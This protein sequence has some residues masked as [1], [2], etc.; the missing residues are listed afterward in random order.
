MARHIQHVILIIADR[1]KS[2]ARRCRRAVQRSDTNPLELIDQ[3][4]FHFTRRTQSLRVIS[5]GV[6][7]LHFVGERVDV[8]SSGV[9][10]VKHAPPELQRLMLSVRHDPGLREVRIQ[11]EDALATHRIAYAALAGIGV[12]ESVYG[13]LRGGIRAVIRISEGVWISGGNSM[14]SGMRSLCADGGSGFDG[15]SG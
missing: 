1:K 7:R 3:R 6:R 4:E 15:R 2:A 11:V 9:G 8:E 13:A 5:E 12:S 10:R 14:A